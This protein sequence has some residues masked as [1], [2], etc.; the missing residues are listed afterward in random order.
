MHTPQLLRR[1][2]NSRVWPILG[3]ILARN[4]HLG[5]V[6]PAML[7]PGILANLQAKED[8]LENRCASIFET[9]PILALWLPLSL[10]PY[11]TAVTMWT[12]QDRM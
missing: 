7:L 4:P 11:S 3:E 1:P 10:K 6:L 12:R 2:E 5:V 9:R 8:P